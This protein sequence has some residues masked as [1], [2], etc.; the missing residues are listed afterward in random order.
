MKVVKYLINLYQ[1][2]CLI[3]QIYFKILYKDRRK[4]IIVVEWAQYKYTGNA[5]SYDLK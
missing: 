4:N 3:N 1:I 2:K 5:K